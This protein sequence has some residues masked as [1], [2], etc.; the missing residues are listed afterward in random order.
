MWA[1][2]VRYPLRIQGQGLLHA[3]Q[4]KEIDDA[5]Y[6]PK[7]AGGGAVL[8]NFPE[9]ALRQGAYGQHQAARKDHDLKTQRFE[10]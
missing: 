10:L 9:D 4:I 3:H 5:P 1:R 2:G 8:T 6:L 7:E